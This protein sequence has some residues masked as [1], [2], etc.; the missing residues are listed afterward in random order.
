M[1]RVRAAAC[2]SSLELLRAGVCMLTRGTHDA[3]GRGCLRQR[4]GAAAR[5]RLHAYQVYA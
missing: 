3:R 5:R 2:A 4:C 1:T